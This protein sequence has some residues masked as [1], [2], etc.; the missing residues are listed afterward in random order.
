[1]AFVPF[2]ELRPRI[3]VAL[4]AE[5]FER[6]RRGNAAYLGADTV[7]PAAS[8]SFEKT[9]AKRVP[10]ARR[11]HDAMWWHR[12][13]VGRLM[14]LEY[15]AAVLS[16]RHD[17]RSTLR[18]NRRLIQAGLLPN[19]FELVVVADHDGGRGHPI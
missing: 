16:P 17:E 11:I 12:R 10:D 2:E 9:A 13:H 6:I 4:A 8:Q 7:T 18:Q 19:Q 5:V 3:G 1:M 15:R 14:P